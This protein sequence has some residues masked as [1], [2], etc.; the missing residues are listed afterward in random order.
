MAMLKLQAPAR[1]QAI[2]QQAENCYVKTIVA[3]TE[4]GYKPAGR[5][6]GYVKTIGACTFLLCMPIYIAPEYYKKITRAL[7]MKIVTGYK[8]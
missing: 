5:N 6:D 8:L 4:A 2:D 1:K 3:C 7:Y